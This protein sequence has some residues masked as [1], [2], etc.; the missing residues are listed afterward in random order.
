MIENDVVLPMPILLIANTQKGQVFNLF[1]DHGS[2]AMIYVSA[3]K[4]FGHE[5]YTSIYHLRQSFGNK[6]ENP[7]QVLLQ[8]QVK[9]YQAHL[10]LIE[11][12]LTNLIDNKPFSEEEFQQD[13][14]IVNSKRNK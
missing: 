7:D 2:S 11:A 12:Y 4:D 3:K 6:I 10:K 13:F 14:F 9:L 8:N 1:S 5:S